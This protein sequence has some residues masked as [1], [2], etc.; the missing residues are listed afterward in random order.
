MVKSA[1]HL[2]ALDGLRGL[3]VL[4]VVGSHAGHKGIYLVPGLD[5]RGTGRLG[6]F[7]FFV[8]SSFLLTHLALGETSERLRS[9]SYWWGYAKRRVLRVMPAFLA[10]LTIYGLDA[11]WDP[12]RALEHVV[13][14]RGERH[15]WTV[16]VEMR[17]YL[18]LPVTIGILVWTRDRSWL[19]PLVLA[20]G[21]IGL[22]FAF[23]PDYGS[24]PP[25][26]R[27]TFFP[28]VPVF[29]MG[30]MAAWLYRRM[31][32]GSSRAQ[33]QGPVLWEGVGWASLV[34]LVAHF[35]ALRQAFTDGIL[36]HTRFHLYF[37][38]IGGLCAL[39][40]LGVLLGMGG[41][42]VAFAL[43]PLRFVGRVSF[44]LYLSHPLLLAFVYR[45]GTTW[46]D[47]LPSLV[48]IGGSL[49]V[50]WILWR[51]IEIPGVKM[52]RAGYVGAT[53]TS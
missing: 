11:G 1:S 46:P 53:R 2:P 18:L 51:W 15:F 19:G 25:D 23:P 13:L 38:R 36:E 24:I 50:A 9:R 40:V 8:L 16:S 12:I 10:V 6:V 41:L 32:V 48:F 17:W 43:A 42:R 31:G 28:F 39:L 35:P 45:H 33:A 49:S 30:C 29:F 37:D 44:S 21:A 20:L 47:P 22:R 34:G 3:A 5:L 27:P 52:A 7:L 14:L 26:F 4:L